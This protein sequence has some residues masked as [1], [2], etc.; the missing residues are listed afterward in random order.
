MECG[1]PV[2]DAYSATVVVTIAGASSEKELY[3]ING[4]IFNIF[5]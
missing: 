4:I 3:F 1:V 5:F 2:I